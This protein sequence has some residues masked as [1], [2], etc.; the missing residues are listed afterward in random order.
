MVLYLYYQIG[1]EK[2][3]IGG[4]IMS[5]YLIGI[6]EQLAEDSGYDMEQ[7][8]EIW[9]DSSEDMTMV[10]FKAITMEHDW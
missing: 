6:M 8:T 1:N 5:D 10:E 4:E 2:Q 3:L 9:L 7:L